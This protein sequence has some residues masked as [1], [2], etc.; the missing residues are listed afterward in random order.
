MSDLNIEFIDI[1]EYM[2]S[3]NDPLNFYPFKTQGH[4]TIEGYK[5]ISN[6]IFKYIKNN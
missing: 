6:E 2:E 5:K 4:F 3:Q 1:K